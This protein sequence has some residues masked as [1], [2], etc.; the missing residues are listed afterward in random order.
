MNRTFWPSEGVWGGGGG[1][2]DI[3]V[4]A[5]PTMLHRVVSS[6]GVALPDGDENSGMEEDWGKENKW[7]MGGALS[8][9]FG[10]CDGMRLGG[11]EWATERRALLN[12]ND[13]QRS[14]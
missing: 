13:L 1:G 12:W 5:S 3:R 6:L 7:V 11:T 9:S 10:M 2:V 4:C 8:R 14:V